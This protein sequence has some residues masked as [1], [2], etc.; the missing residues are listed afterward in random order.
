MDELIIL[1]DY[2]TSWKSEYQK[3]KKDWE[4]ILDYNLISIHHIGSTAIPGIKSKTI[5]DI[6]IEVDSMSHLTAEENYLI[7][8]GYENKGEHGIDGRCFF[9]KLVDGKRKF[10]I[11]CFQHNHPLLALH[12]KFKKALLADEKLAKEYEA[13][14][15]KLAKKFKTNRTAYNEGKNEFINKILNT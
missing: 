12:L 10:H 15:I 3:E 5:I 14:K 7:E 1:E 13:L 4:I 2:N 9:Q 6:L 11:H 8:N